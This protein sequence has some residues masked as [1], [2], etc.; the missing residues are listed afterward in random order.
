ML[1]RIDTFLGTATWYQLTCSYR[2]EKKYSFN[3]FYTHRMTRRASDVAA[4]E[5][6]LTVSVGSI[7]GTVKQ[8]LLNTGATVSDALAAAGFPSDSEVRCNGEVYQGADILE[9]GDSLI[10]LA[11]QKVKGGV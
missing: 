7:G 11:G 1:N 4:A 9:A 2:Q 5:E 6:T 3:H 10:V 8:V